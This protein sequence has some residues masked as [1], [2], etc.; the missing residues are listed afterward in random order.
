MQNT[1][2][3]WLV[4]AKTHLC[5]NSIVPLIYR[6][7]ALSETCKQA[8][9]CSDLICLWLVK[10]FILGPYCIQAKIFCGQEPDNIDP[11]Q[12]VHSTIMTFMHFLDSG[13]MASSQSR[14]FSHFSFH[15]RN[16]WYK[17]SF[18]VQSILGPSI[19]GI[20]ISGTNCCI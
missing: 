16:L 20:N 5:L 3:F 9:S 8:K 19:Y 15:L 6:T 17:L 13:N 4:F 1:C 14:I 10:I 7:I 11:L 12:N 18:T 2:S